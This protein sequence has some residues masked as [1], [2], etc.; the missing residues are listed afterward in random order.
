MKRVPLAALALAFLSFAAGCMS[1]QYEGG[2]G[3]KATSGVKV[4]SD[5][6][7]IG[8]PYSVL[9]EAKVSGNYQEVSRDRMVKKLISEAEECGADAILVVEQQVIPLTEGN[10]GGGFLTAFDYDDTNRSWS[11]L[12]RDVDQRYGNIRNRQVAGPSGSSLQIRYRRVIRAE[13][14]KYLPEGAASAAPAGREA[15]EK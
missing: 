12:Y 9:G 1:Y 4:F 15:P 14:L 11:Q 6:S 8:R 13:F 10:S 5:S 3:E 7:R 2:R